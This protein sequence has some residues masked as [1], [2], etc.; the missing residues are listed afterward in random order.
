MIMLHV[1]VR[2]VNRITP[3]VVT[4]SK[5]GYNALLGR[6]WTHGARVVPSIL[7]QKLI[8][9]NDE[10]K[11]EEVYA[12]DSCCYLQQVDADFKVYNPK[13]KPLLLDNSTLN[14]DLIEG[15]FFRPNVVY[16][17]FLRPR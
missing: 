5:A 10:V 16:I 2:S 8:I 12:N 14:S 17:L 9:W 15:C 11:V 1:K 13:E 7:H 3:F 6:E 4:T